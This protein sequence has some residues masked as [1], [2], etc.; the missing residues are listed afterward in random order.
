LRRRPTQSG[1]H[2]R[3]V[4]PEQ[5]W[6]PHRTSP[7]GATRE[8]IVDQLQAL[9]R[10]VS[11]GRRSAVTCRLAWLPASS[12]AWQLVELIGKNR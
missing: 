7:V 9:R 3:E 4:D 10:W 11:G 12:Y 5:G 2:D 8:S 6:M 1:T